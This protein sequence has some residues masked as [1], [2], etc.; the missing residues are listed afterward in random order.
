[1]KK[2]T[3]ILISSTVLTVTACNMTVEENNPQSQHR[4]TT[5][6]PA[7]PVITV[8]EEISENDSEL[9]GFS[10]PSFSHTGE[11][12]SGTNGS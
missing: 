10:L 3:A 5:T 7:I 8:D 4:L 12:R 1:M 9:T 2:S 11:K 6:E